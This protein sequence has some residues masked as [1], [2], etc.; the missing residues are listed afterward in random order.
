[1]RGIPRSPIGWLHPSRI[2][3]AHAGNTHSAGAL[4]R[5]CWDQPRTCGEYEGAAA[6]SQL[7]QG[8]APHMRGIHHLHHASPLPPRISPAHAGNTVLPLLPHFLPSDQ[9]RTCGEYPFLLYSEVELPGSAPH[10]RGI[11]RAGVSRFLGRRDQPR[12]CGEYEGAAAPSQPPQGS[13]PHMRGIPGAM[14]GSCARSDQPRT[15]GE[16]PRPRRGRRRRNGSAPHMRGIP[17]S[18]GRW[19]GDIGISPA[20]AGNTRRGRKP[21]PPRTDQPRTCGEY[22]RSV[23]HARSPT[24]ISPAHA[25]NTEGVFGD[26]SAVADQPRTCGEYAPLS[27]S[28]PQRRGSAPHMR[29]IQIR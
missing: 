2:S 23:A 17:Q 7:L 24:R 28:A 20:H 6:P 5:G 19:S 13:A 21:Q 11:P 25:G 18:R 12:T 9:P 15:C 22:P 27:A 4:L 29:G 16:Y 8:S 26:E 3:P 14:G 10:M 1:M